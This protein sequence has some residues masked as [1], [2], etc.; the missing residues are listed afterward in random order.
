MPV[1]LASACGDEL[2]GNDTSRESRP[3]TLISM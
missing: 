3:Q 1:T 2:P